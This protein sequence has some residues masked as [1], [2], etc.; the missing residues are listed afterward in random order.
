VRVALADDG[1]PHYQRRPAG[2]IVDA[3]E[4]R[5]RE[6]SR[7]Y[8]TIPATVI[9]ERIGW[10]R[11]ITVLEDRVAQ[12]RPVYFAAGSGDPDELSGWGDCPV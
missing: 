3:A 12:L 5:I 6:L 10:D 4:P 11:A 1:P 2:S 9:A 7:A 8:R